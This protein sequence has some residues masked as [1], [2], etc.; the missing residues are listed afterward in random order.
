MAHEATNN[1]PVNLNCKLTAPELRMR[2]ATVI[3]ALQRQVL[4]KKELP[5]GFAFK[6]DSSDA[7]LNML[8]QF[9]QTERLC[10]SFFTFTVQVQADASFIWLHLSGPEGTKPFITSE[11]GL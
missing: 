10:C 7:T 1:T 3:A 4:E 11:L 5:D 8:T 2:K 6:F 9:I